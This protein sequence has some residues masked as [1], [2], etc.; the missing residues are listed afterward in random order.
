MECGIYDDVNILHYI[1]RVWGIRSGSLSLWS[2]KWAVVCAKWPTPHC[3][4]NL[5]ELGSKMHLRTPWGLWS[6]WFIIAKY[7]TSMDFKLFLGESDFPHAF[8]FLPTCLKTNTNCSVA[9]YC[10]HLQGIGR[11]RLLRINFLMYICTLPDNYRL[12]FLGHN[13]CSAKSVGCTVRACSNRITEHIKSNVNSCALTLNDCSSPWWIYWEGESCFYSQMNLF[14][15]LMGAIKNDIF[16]F[17]LGGLTRTAT[18]SYCSTQERG[19]RWRLGSTVLYRSNTLVYINMEIIK[20]VWILC[21]GLCF[22]K[23]WSM[24]MSDKSADKSCSLQINRNALLHLIFTT[25]V[26]SRNTH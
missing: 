19:L 21:F 20:Y 22:K 26:L 24:K 14:R 15:T 1:D 9:T 17:R 10:L 18:V 25:I 3:S 13:L 8:F 4:A 6:G 7:C 23:Y 2:S 12:V 11:N 5:L 16:I